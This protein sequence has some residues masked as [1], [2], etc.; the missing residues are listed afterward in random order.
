M[1][2]GIPVTQDM[3]LSRLLSLV[4]GAIFIV[5][6]NILANKRKD[7]KL[8]KETIDNLVNE[9]DNAID[10]KLNGKEVS[11]DKKETLAVFPQG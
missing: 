8:S 2:V 9:L 7:Y 4:F 5:G 11:V 1:M 6:I 3:L 10:L